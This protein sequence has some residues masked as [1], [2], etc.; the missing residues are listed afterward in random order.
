MPVLVGLLVPAG[1]SAAGEDISHVRHRKY[2]SSRF[3][4]MCRHASVGGATTESLK[5]QD[6]V[7]GNIGL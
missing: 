4:K 1:E 2:V 5:V 3:V 7:Q 6:L